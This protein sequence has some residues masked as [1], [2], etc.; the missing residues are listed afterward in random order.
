MTTTDENTAAEDFTPIRYL[1]VELVVKNTAIKEFH[2]QV[3]GLIGLISETF[4]W[5]F[6]YAAY[7][8]SGKLNHIVHLW[9]IPSEASLLRL[10]QIGS[11]DVN[12]PDRTVIAS[13]EAA[14]PDGRP[15]MCAPSR[16]GKM[17]AQSDLEKEF[18]VA[19][20]SVLELLEDTTHTLMASLS[21][22][23]TFFGE[24]TQTVVVDTEG[25]YFL[26]RHDDLRGL[27]PVNCSDELRTLLAKGPTTGMFADRPFFNL[28]ELKPVSVFQR[29]DTIPAQKARRT[30]DG[31]SYPV[32]LPILVAA[33][34][35]QV[36]ELSDRE[37]ALK[38]INDKADP[39]MDESPLTATQRILKSLIEA[40]VPL[41]S[42]PEPVD[43]PIGEGCV[44]NLINLSSFR[45]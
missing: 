3:P 8:T 12:T 20:Q 16:F 28:A 29:I 21:H 5:E 13:P 37:N 7:P 43:G 11:D 9:R 42:I 41:A 14:G 38:P 27:R 25:K 18:R 19:Y 1:L 39:G 24:Q 44:C 22:D 35:G 31:S 34:W 32:G 2:K 23:P 45:G 6:M 17:K 10:M 33:P 30:R 36:Y 15:G 26:L 40:K 4:N